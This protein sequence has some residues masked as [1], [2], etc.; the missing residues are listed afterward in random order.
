[1]TS[2]T[3]HKTWAAAPAVTGGR[4]M[5]RAFAGL[6]AGGATVVLISLA[7]WPPPGGFPLWPAIGSCAFA[8]VVA[9]G[10]LHERATRLPRGAFEVL[11]AV[12]TLLITVVFVASGA[13]PDEPG[14]MLYLWAAPF[15][16]WFSPLRRALAQLLLIA[17]CYAFDL[18]VSVGAS[19]TARGELVARWVMLVGTLF[20]LGLLVR[21]LAGELGR[22][23]ARREHELRRRRREADKEAAEQASLRRVATAVAEEVDLQRLFELA[24]REA[25][26]LFHVEYTAIVRFESDTHVTIVGGWADGDA[27]EYASGK[28]LNVM[29]GGPVE[30]LRAVRG[31][32]RS[33]FSNTDVPYPYR[34]CAPVRIGGQLWGMFVVGTHGPDA[35][36]RVSE[37]R[38][39]RFADLIALAIANAEA[40]ERLATLAFSDSLTGLA[41]HRH[42]QDRLT[43]EIDRAL[44]T[45]QPLSLVMLDVDQ[46]KEVNDGHGHGVGDE[47]LRT[48]ASRLRGAARGDGLLARIG[49]DEFALLLPGADCARALAR[50][51]Q[52]RAAVS[53]EPFGDIGT[54]TLSAGA[55]DLEPAGGRA[56][57][58]RLADAALYWAKGHGRNRAVRYSAGEVLDMDDDDHVVRSGQHTTL[59][60]LCSLARA[61][62]ARDPAMRQHSERVASLAVTLAGLRGWSAEDQAR[63]RAAGLIHDVGLL[64]VSQELAADAPDHA[65]AGARMAGEVLDADQTSWILHHHDGVDDGQLPEGAALIGLAEAWDELTAVEGLTLEG[66]L[67]QCRRGAGTRFDAAA[68]AALEQLIGPR[69]ATQLAA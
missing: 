60:A 8:Y 58:L 53:A 17:G 28:Q 62:D 11:V 7:L 48:V 66:A 27:G 63:L 22:E 67:E 13:P 25:A 15:G 26:S 52:L 16:F 68:V 3:N 40:R 38:L 19:H 37:E 1:M 12:A 42:F 31:P 5:A 2:W 30:Q 39:E 56:E 69:I 51:E 34:I 35:F 65:A 50:A 14:V 47:L 61:I 49:G 24:A 21:V 57:L 41:N 29:S 43:D 10:S 55:C 44:A 18:A 36:A 54:I 33:L 32:I 59:R 23:Q 46:L 64:G 9:A 4:V 20:A 6:F 45:G